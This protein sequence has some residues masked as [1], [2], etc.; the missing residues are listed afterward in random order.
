MFLVDDS[1]DGNNCKTKI[2]PTDCSNEKKNNGGMQL[3][4]D[5]RDHYNG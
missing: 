2:Q 4:R 5:V 1:V 3:L